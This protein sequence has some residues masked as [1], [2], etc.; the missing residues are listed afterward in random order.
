MLR[1]GLVL[2]EEQRNRE[3]EIFPLK[4]IAET[5]WKTL[6]STQDLFF[7]VSSE[8]GTFTCCLEINLGT[9]NEDINVSPRLGWGS[10]PPEDHS[11]HL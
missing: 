7:N 4:Q 6:I 9:G 10:H 3:T 11:C 5:P 8:G 1:T 2:P